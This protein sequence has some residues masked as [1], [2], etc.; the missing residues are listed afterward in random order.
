MIIVRANHPYLRVG[1]HNL[2]KFKLSNL[3]F[4]QFQ[5]SALCCIIMHIVI[6]LFNFIFNGI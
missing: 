3:S 6:Y 1:C 5:F 4:S 2:C